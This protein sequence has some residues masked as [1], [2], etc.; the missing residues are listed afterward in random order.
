MS[1]IK[2]VTI[3]RLYC[4]GGSSIGKMVAEKLGIPCYDREIVEMAAEKSGISMADIKKYEESVL[5][6]LK[7]QVSFFKS[8]EDITEK[9]FAAETQVVYELVE[10]GPCVIVGRCADFI[11]KNKVKTL[12]VFIYSSLD[13]RKQ[14]A[15]AAPHNI[16]EDEVENRIKKYDKKRGDYYNTNTNKQW[17]SKF[18]YDLCLDSGTLGYDM[19]AEIIAH[20]VEASE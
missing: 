10:K 15:M 6:P 3:G 7:K 17:S 12:D 5:N 20:T 8:S 14:T 19:C 18:S 9:I 4:S 1:K 11:L 2:V 16:P 13:K